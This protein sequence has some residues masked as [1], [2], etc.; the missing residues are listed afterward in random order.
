MLAC[1]WAAA[2]AVASRQEDLQ[3]TTVPLQVLLFL[4]FFAAMYVY[5]PGPVLTALSYLPFTA[6]IAMPRRIA[7]GDAAWWEA[8]L[9]AVVLALT[10]AA[11]IAVATRVYERSVLR[12]GTR[13]AWG[14]ALGIGR[15][16]GAEPLPEGA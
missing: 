15:R 10:A 5:T 11:F 4:P 9:A 14:A 16:R 2:G 7:L 12:A 1:L 8:P 3:A 13:V 6:P